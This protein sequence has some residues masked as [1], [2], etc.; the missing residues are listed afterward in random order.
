[1]V[2]D[3]TDSKTGLLLPPLYVILWLAAR[4]S[5]MPF[6]KNYCDK[7]YLAANKILKFISNPCTLIPVEKMLDYH[8]DN[9]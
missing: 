6:H 2:K 8:Y 3:H 1:M 9:N 5:Y 7:L 4:Y